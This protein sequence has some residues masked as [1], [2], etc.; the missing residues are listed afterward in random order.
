MYVE[1][2]FTIQMIHTCVATQA[3]V[4][5]DNQLH[6]WKRHRFSAVFLMKWTTMHTCARMLGF[7]LGY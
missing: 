1:V 7:I 2:R 3:S 6:N 5:M 4:W